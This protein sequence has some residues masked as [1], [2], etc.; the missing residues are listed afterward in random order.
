MSTVLQISL[1][2]FILSLAM[3]IILGVMKR[4]VG[5]WIIIMFV[6]SIVQ[7]FIPNQGITDPYHAA[8]QSN[9]KT[10][11]TFIESNNLKD[12]AQ[13]QSSSIQYLERIGKLF[14]EDYYKITLSQTEYIYFGAFKN[15]LP[16]GLGMILIETINSKHLDKTI[17]IPLY[18]GYFK[19]GRYS[20]YGKL[21]TEND[22]Y[23]SNGVDAY[24]GEYGMF[25]KSYEGYFDN[26]K[27]SGKGNYHIDLCSLDEEKYAEKYIS[28][29]RKKISEMDEEL[30]DPTVPFIISDL[31]PLDTFLAYYGDFIGGSSDGYGKSENENGV[32]IYNGS[33][34]NG[35]YDGK[36]KEFYP[37]GALKYDGTFK[38]GKYNG[39]GTM[40]NPDGSVKYS[41]E[42]ENSN[43]K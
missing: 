2:G 42:W 3:T 1:I 21:F 26:G 17:Y 39:K 35:V 7:Y 24:F 30:Q 41:G 31:P 25:Y 13:I 36:G 43:F 32:I 33:Y 38:S 37:N 6:C 5:F 28:D 11:Y 29:N 27:F 23:S 16:N 14:S 40:Y 34:K 9:D 12:L 20:G 18:T 10:G 4:K 15:N 19:D 8:I 22:Y